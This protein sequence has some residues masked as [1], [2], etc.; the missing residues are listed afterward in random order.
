MPTAPKVPKPKHSRT[1]KRKTGLTPADVEAIRAVIHLEV[2]ELRVK[3]DALTEALPSRDEFASRMDEVLGTLNAIRD[4]LTAL[5][6]RVSRHE[7]RITVLEEI[8]PGGQHL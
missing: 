5:S 4:E 7:D 1:P 6:F 8:H 2:D 3:V